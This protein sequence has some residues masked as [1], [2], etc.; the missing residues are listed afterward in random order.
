MINAVKKVKFSTLVVLMALPFAP[1]FLFNIACGITNVNFKKFF[2]SVL[3]SKVSIIYFWGFIGTSLLD[4]IMDIT[5]LV[6]VV[7]MVLV[8][9]IISK[10]VMKKYNIE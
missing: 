2:L 4:S 6:R 5:I 9:F 8:A 1:A 10:F 3:I 7:I